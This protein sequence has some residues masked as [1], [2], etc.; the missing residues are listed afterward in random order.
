M[1]HALRWILLLP[2]VL[3]SWLG[4]FYVFAEYHRHL[5]APCDSA[6]SLPECTDPLR[7]L[8]VNTLPSIGAAVSAVL[9]L[10]VTYLIAPTARMKAVRICFGVGA[11]IAFAGAWANA[12]AQSWGMF[13]AACAALVAGTIAVLVMSKMAIPR[14]A[15]MTPNTSFE[16]TREG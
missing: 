6:P 10:V 2:G 11:A 5:T 12:V 3:A 15:A 14:E 1:G 9:V 4:T 8:L 7:V 13:S 16:R